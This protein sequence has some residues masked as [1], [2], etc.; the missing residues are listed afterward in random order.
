MIWDE[1]ITSDFDVR[2]RNQDNCPWFNPGG[3]SVDSDHARSCRVDNLFLKL[4]HR[5]NLGNIIPHWTIK[6]VTRYDCALCKGTSEVRRKHSLKW[7][8]H[9][10]SLVVLQTKTCSHWPLLR[11]WLSPIWF[12]G[13]SDN[14]WKPYGMIN[15]LTFDDLWMTFMKVIIIL[16]L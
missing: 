8:N 6:N 15:Y 11:T 10:N 13:T 16:N 1:Y 4:T 9:F 5:S 7:R 14:V 3:V 2:P 12:I